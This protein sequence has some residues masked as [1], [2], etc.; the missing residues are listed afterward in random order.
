MINMKKKILFLA[1]C[2]VAFGTLN[3]LSGS[4]EGGCFQQQ[5][6]QEPVYCKGLGAACGYVTS[7]PPVWCDEASSWDS[8][9]YFDSF[10][11]NVL[12]S[13]YI[14]GKCSAA[15]KGTC[16]GAS[17]NVTAS[18]KKLPTFTSSCPSY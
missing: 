2:V 3:Q 15:R 9:C 4:T 11:V 12:F 17:L 7:Y 5:S 16:N 13:E 10:P 18:H 14:G 8:D 1:V 6:G